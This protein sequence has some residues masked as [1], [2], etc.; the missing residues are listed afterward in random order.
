MNRRRFTG[1]LASLLLCVSVFR[2][3]GQTNFRVDPPGNPNL[4]HWQDNATNWIT[5]SNWWVSGAA[6]RFLTNQFPSSIGGGGSDATKVLIYSGGSSNQTSTNRLNLI[7]DHAYRYIGGILFTNAQD[8]TDGLTPPGCGY[9]WL[10][11]PQPSAGVLSN[12]NGKMIIDTGLYFCTNWA[13]PYSLNSTLPNGTKVYTNACNFKRLTNSFTCDDPAG[14]YLLDGD[15]PANTYTNACLFTI[16]GS[17]PCPDHSGPYYPFYTNSDDVIIY[18]NACGITATVQLLCTNGDVYT[19]D[20]MFVTNDFKINGLYHKWDAFGQV[21]TNRIVNSTNA[22][23]NWIAS[24]I[25]IT[26]SGAGTPNLNGTYR[27]FYRQPTA[28]NSQENYFDGL[29]VWTN[30][31]F[32]NMRIFHTGSVWTMG[33]NG[34]PDYTAYTASEPTNA[35]WTLTFGTGA[36]PAPSGTYFVQPV[37]TNYTTNVETVM[38]WSQYIGNSD[39]KFYWA[40]NAQFIPPGPGS[41][42][43]NI[44]GTGPFEEFYLT[45]MSTLFLIPD[46]NTAYIGSGG[47]KVTF[48]TA[49]NSNLWYVCGSGGK[50]GG[51]IF[52]NEGAILLT[53]DPPTG[54]PGS[55]T[56]SPPCIVTTNDPSCSSSDVYFIVGCDCR[57][58]ADA[59]GMQDNST[60]QAQQYGPGPGFSIDGFGT[61]KYTYWSVTQAGRALIT[62]VVATWPDHG[63]SGLVTPAPTCSAQGGYGFYPKPIVLP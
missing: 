9:I 17:R 51:N 7:D 14:P 41:P 27:Q 24:N 50:I 45:N 12:C 11:G 8:I 47:Q 46:T 13:G 55:P 3:A 23:V 25:V 44:T 39:V 19:A 16:T 4:F 52:N 37:L 63:W 1:Y 60:F 53:W 31:T 34:V 15:L 58:L 62:D 30:A 32:D 36:A 28:T 38:A 48:T 18:S 22:Y 56:N 26:I 6:Y 21:F 33:S 2:S 59:K 42:E 61:V 40:T 20:T 35:S 57:K 54:P 29:D 49:I 10:S 5:I 43:I